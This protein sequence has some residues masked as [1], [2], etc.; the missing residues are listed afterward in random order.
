HAGVPRARIYDVLRSLIDRGFASS[1]P[2]DVIRYSAMPPAAAV[3]RL[4]DEH[5]ERMK[6]IESTGSELIER[7]EPEFASGRGHTEPLDFIQ[8]LRG[9]APISQYTAELSE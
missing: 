4:L 9:N 6:D 1:R 2:G 5:R 7:L 8:V 3:G